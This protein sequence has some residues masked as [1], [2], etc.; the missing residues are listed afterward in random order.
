MLKITD[1]VYLTSAV[2]KAQFLKT[3]KP[4][5]AVSGKSNV[6]KSSF[7]NML[8]N[9]KKL[10]RVS[11]DPGRTRMVN[12]F[13]F[14]SFILA[15]LPG[16]GYAKVSHAEKLRWAKLMQDFF[17][18]SS[19]LTHVLALCDIRHPPTQDDKDMINFL[20]ASL[21]PFT[22]VATKADKVS[23]SAAQ[24]GAKLIANTF[25]CGVDNVII[26]SSENRYGK[27]AVLDR[28]E[29]VIQLYAQDTSELSEEET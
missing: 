3:D 23:R 25:A 14:G 4:V 1:A 17:A 7:I 15:D 13:D 11:K 10:A 27:E 22:I 2:S 21:I 12:Y 5:I 8:A 20:Y 28:I 26:T 18:D 9:R 24:N 29:G 16:Y 19:N 6:G